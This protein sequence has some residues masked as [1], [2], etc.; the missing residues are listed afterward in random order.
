MSRSSFVWQR[1]YEG[2][3]CVGHDGSGNNLRIPK[4][5]V[6]NAAGSLS[7]TLEDY[8]LYLNR[9]LY[10][11]ADR[12]KEMIKSQ[13]PITSR[14]QFGP[15]AILDVHDNDS[16][17]LSYGLG[18]GVY[19]TPY[20]KAFFKEGH[21]EGWQH[22]FVGFPERGFGLLMMAN[23]DQAESIFEELIEIIEA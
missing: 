8:T 1:A 22:Y 19:Q 7:T 21:L 10:Q 4:S 20:G 15:N 11:R 17:G 12:Y 9:I 6:A 5:N 3:Y 14:Q 16:I 18:V 13:V 23:S 2:N